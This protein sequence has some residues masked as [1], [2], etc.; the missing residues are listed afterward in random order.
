[1]IGS[2][3]IILVFPFI[4]GSHALSN[5]FEQPSAVGADEDWL[6]IQDCLCQVSGSLGDCT[7]DVESIDS[8]NSRLIYP[9]LRELTY[10]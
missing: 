2:L 9:A 5:P 8:Y 7:C 6:G 3:I 10:R 1:M 4:S